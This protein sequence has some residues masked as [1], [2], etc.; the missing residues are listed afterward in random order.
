[1]TTSFGVD[2]FHIN[3]GDGECTLH[4]LVK[5][6]QPPANSEVIQV[7]LVD[8]GPANASRNGTQ[9]V[10]DTIQTIARRYGLENLALDAVVIS[11][12]H[13]DY[14][15]G[16]FEMLAADMALSPQVTALSNRGRLDGFR[17]SWLK[18]D[19]HG[20]PLTTLYVPCAPPSHVAELQLDTARTGLVYTNPPPE[21]EESKSVAGFCK[22]VYERVEL[23]G[24][25]LFSG[26]PPPADF[27]SSPAESPHKLLMKNPPAGGTPGMYI[28]MANGV[29]IGASISEKTGKGALSL[30]LIWDKKAPCVSYLGAG[31]L[32]ATEESDVMDWIMTPPSDVENEGLSVTT[33]KIGYRNSDP[34]AAVRS[35]DI[36]RPKNIFM[37][38]GSKYDSPRECLSCEAAT[39]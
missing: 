10:P 39:V 33:M 36:A 32:N 5:L 24:R 29:G 1:M 3:V 20:I 8:S 13:P 18:Y 22:V 11:C 26:K 2:S 35:V 27:V 38:C 16:F 14:Y 37:F 6:A 4:V 9:I 28:I 12:W 21:V 19:G 30:A 15:G 7:V 25:D 23:L 17:G 31:T 34:V